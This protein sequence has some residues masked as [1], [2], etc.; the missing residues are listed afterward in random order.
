[1]Q[2]N[3]C[4]LK[5]KGPKPNESTTV[6][7]G[8]KGTGNIRKAIFSEDF[9]IWPVSADKIIHNLFKIM[10][11]VFL[12]LPAS[13]GTLVKFMFIFSVFFFS[14]L[15][16]L[17]MNQFIIF[18]LITSFNIIYLLYS[19][20]KLNIID[21]LSIRA[22]LSYQ[23]VILTTFALVWGSYNIKKEEIFKLVVI[24]ASL[25]SLIKLIVIF[26]PYFGF[27]TAINAGFVM[28]LRGQGFSRI[29]T[30]NDLILPLAIFLILNRKA[31]NLRLGQ[32]VSILSLLILLST[33][34][35]TFT[36]Y[37]WISTFIAVSGY[38][39][40]NFRPIIK[41]S[42]NKK[43]ILAALT[44]SIIFVL[45]LLFPSSQI[46]GISENIFIRSTDSR[47]IDVK[48]EQAR[49]LLTNFA[50]APLL[51][52]GNAAFIKDYIRYERL[53][54]VYETQWI[55][56]LYQFGLIGAASIVVFLLLPIFPLLKHILI[57]MET[58]KILF[59][60]F[61]LYIGFLFSGFTNPNLF[62]LNSSIVYFI[63][64]IMCLFCIDKKRKCDPE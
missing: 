8:Q 18:L 2:L 30:S 62:T 9:A 35:L 10:L 6:G 7:T 32:R 36:R 26:T 16:G 11:I 40:L 58:S 28:D 44:L 56:I 24:G 12:I 3:S 63:V 50:D 47:S 31:F 42:E 20:I 48:V 60:I 1:M 49:Y 5:G 55:V 57:H 39:L 27:M 38:I 21:E 14:F 61:V 54:F 33:S 34:I 59:I 13:L 25:Y 46:E 51:G 52:A 41:S 22:F 4:A 37:I 64:Y 15:R 19:I 43:I 23:G 45:F 53:P 17:K 29:A